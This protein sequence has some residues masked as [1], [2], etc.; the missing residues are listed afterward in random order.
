MYAATSVRCGGI[1]TLS[2][3]RSWRGMTREWTDIDK[4]PII[5]FEN[6]RAVWSAT[7]GQQDSRET[8]SGGAFGAIFAG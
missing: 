1:A 5:G 4:A 6:E 8:I 7:G 2:C 3:G